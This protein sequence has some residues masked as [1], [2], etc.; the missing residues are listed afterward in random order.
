[1]LGELGSSGILIFTAVLVVAA[2]VVWLIVD[3]LR[4]PD[5]SAGKKALW[6]VL[7][8]PFTIITLLAYLIFGR[9]KARSAA[10]ARG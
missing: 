4:R 10:S 1:M 8:F 3:V 5:L 9:R 7:A 2:A 6:I